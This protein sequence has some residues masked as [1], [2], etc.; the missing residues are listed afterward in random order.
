[1]VDDV[2]ELQQENAKLRQRVGELQGALAAQDQRERKAGEKCGVSYQE[3]G[4]DW[5][6]A[7]AERLAW[8]QHRVKDLQQSLELHAHLYQ[9]LDRLPKVEGEIHTSFDGTGVSWWVE[10]A[11]EKKAFAKVYGQEC[12][13]AVANLL[14]LRQARP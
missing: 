2:A 12:A 9:A 5:P 14:R 3:H 10:G 13:E 11:Q 7:I 6:D 8:S 4:C 1:M